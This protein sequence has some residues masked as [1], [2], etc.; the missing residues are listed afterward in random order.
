MSNVKRDD[1]MSPKLSE[2]IDNNGFSSYE[3]F[4]KCITRAENLV[5]VNESTKCID[6]IDIGEGHYCDCY[7][8]SVVLSISAL[9]AFIRKILITKIID[10]LNTKS[11]LNKKLSDYIKSLLN[12]DE[13]LEAARE[14]DLTD[15]VEKAIKEDFEKKSFQGGWKISSFLELIGFKNVF[16]EV[17]ERVNENESNLRRE[18]DIFT[19]RRHVI[20]HSGD[21]DLNQSPMKENKIDRKFAENCIETVKKFAKA[22]NDL[23]EER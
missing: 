15:R 23:I 13:L 8:A 22:I 5:Q 19:K 18:I 4:E 9:D 16:S 20:A 6:K 2:L 11:K 21:Y 17:S 7:R 1:E 12:Q 14:F 10:R 3:I